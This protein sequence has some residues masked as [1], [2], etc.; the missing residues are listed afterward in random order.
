[1]QVT[2]MLEVN[3]IKVPLEAVEK[4][5]AITELLDLLREQGKLDD[6]DTVLKAIMEREAVRSTGV[7]QGF[8]IPHAKLSA[9]KQMVMAL[10]KPTEPIDFQSIDGKPVTIVILLLSPADRTGPHIQALARISRM[11]TEARFREQ[12]WS[13]SSAQQL[14]EY[15]VAYEQRESAAID[16]DS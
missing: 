9:V 10:G 8:A 1:M 2:D 6:Y 7:G 12:L 16:N 5:Q 3:C 15:I 11:M 13:C 14:H 4:Y